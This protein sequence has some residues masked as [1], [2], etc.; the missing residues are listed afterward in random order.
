M[1]NHKDLDDDTPIDSRVH[2]TFPFPVRSKRRVQ[3]LIAVT[4]LVFLTILAHQTII[5]KDV[6]TSEPFE[7]L[8]NAYLDHLATPLTGQRV[9]NSKHETT[10]IVGNHH[11]VSGN[12]P[13]NYQWIDPYSRQP[14]SEVMYKNGMN[15]NAMGRMPKGSQYDVL[16]VARGRNDQYMDPT[17]GI[18]YVNLT[19]VG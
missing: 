15:N 3:C 11:E 7:P 10:F 4:A 2:K 18:K 9:T 12:Y 8:D 14:F 13:K 1:P 16:V 6:P 17:E 19:I 5:W